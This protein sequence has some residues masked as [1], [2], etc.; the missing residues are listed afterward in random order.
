MS[1]S[2]RRFFRNVGLG[3]AGLLST[4]FVIGRGREA[5]AFEPGVPQPPNDNGFIRISSNENARGPGKKTIDAL[6][7]AI[8]PRVGRGYPPDYTGDLVDTIAAFYKVDKDHI[9]VGTGSGPILD[10]GT[11]A[12]CSPTK[13]L[14]TAAPTYGTPDQAARRINAPVKMIHV[15][16]SL[17]LDLDAM[18]EA[19]KGA[20]MIF[21]C[22]PN[23]PTGTV[24]NLAAVER[25]VRKVK[26]V[27]PQTKILIDEAYID[28]AHDPA[29]KTA[30]PLTR[31]LPGVFVTRSFSKA[32]GMAGLRLGYAVG[33]AETL[34]AISNAWSLGSV[35]TL[36]AAAGVASLRDA[37]HIDEERA[38]NA[39][40][41]DFTLNAFKSLGF[42]APDSHT[43]CIFVD[44]KRP[45][46]EF[47]DACAAQKVS[48]GRDF[49]PFEK[50]HSRITLGSMDEMKQAVD[51][52]K[53]VLN[54]RSTSA[55]L[56]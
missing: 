12:F 54:T 45:A 46:K 24:H 47:R 30:V 22:N 9:I 11:R 16:K 51:V 38:E 49:P 41:R 7:N 29:V 42:E 44:L 25:F 5:M 26:E 35:N 32:H 33:Q 4:S 23:N 19:A 37:K 39:R 28:Y 36:S 21:F 8:S 40:V 10:G 1:L 17:G 55:G 43:N 15:D 53:R 2:R 3:S 14:V 6:H 20:G 56:R 52:F 27:S 13:P 48:I 34:K 18:A 31:E 50:T